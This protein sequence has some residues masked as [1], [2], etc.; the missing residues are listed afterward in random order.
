M[1]TGAPVLGGTTLP[2]AISC[3]VTEILVGEQSESGNGTNLLD[4]TAVKWAWAV[5]FPY[6]TEAEKDVLHERYA[7]AGTQSWQAPDGTATY[8]VVV[9]R[10]SWKEG[11]HL[12][13]ASGEPY[14]TV[15]F[16]LVEYQ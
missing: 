4:Y 14:Y 10:G 9:K 2:K 5:T 11:Q 12:Q 8:T 15:S 16:E 6:R 13:I 7:E 3:D 1:S